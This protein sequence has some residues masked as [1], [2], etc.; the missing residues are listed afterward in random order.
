MNR[1]HR[2]ALKPTPN[3]EALF[4]QHAGYARFAYNWALGEFRAG[5]DVGEWL[6]ER[7]LRPRWNKVKGMIA[8]WGLELSQN[9]AKYAIVD[10][11]QASESWGKYRR[12]V[13]SGHCPGR[14]VGFPRFKRRKHAQGFRADNG[15]DT[16]RVDGKVV[17]LPKIGRV[18]MVE[19]L[20]FNGSIREVTVNRTAG[21]WFAC[22]CVEDGHE[23]PPVKDGPT[24]GVDV[25][26][27][28]MATC[29]DGT[30]VENPK[31]LASALKRLRRVDKA[32][33]RSRSVHGKSSHSNRLERLYARRRRLHARVV[34]VRSD[35]HHKATTAIAKSAGRVVVETLN[36]A[37][38]IRNRRLARAIADAG[39]SG[40]LIKLE[41]KCAWYGAEYVKVDRWYPSSKLCSHCGWKND[42]LALS[43][44]EWWCGGCGVLNE[45]DANA[46]ENLA[47]WPGWSFPVTGRGDRVRPAMLAVVGEA[48]RVSGPEVWTPANLEYQISSDSK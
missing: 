26:V 10:F 34:N 13:K 2:I 25:G 27:G 39:I 33:A 19:E 20:R 16:V 4:G 1:S 18:A 42:D 21:T 43:D 15:P 6:S 35:H 38:M 29:S 12:K 24:V 23:Q 37:G 7:T 11:G 36:V 3:Q 45:R 5:L 48:S 8:P 17:I 44:R 30:V 47:N 41:Y 9:A 31:P 22:F 32:I 40:F 14:R 28:T 46:A